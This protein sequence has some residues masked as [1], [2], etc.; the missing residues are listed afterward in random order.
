MGEVVTPLKDLSLTVNKEWDLGNLGTTDMYLTRT[1]EMDLLADGEETGLTGTLNYQ[2]DWS[3]TFTN[4]PQFDSDGVEIEYTVKEVP[5][6]VGWNV[7]YGPV[8]E[9]GENAY[10]T[11][12]TNTYAMT[13]Q[14]PETGGHGLLPYTIGGALL[15]IASGI[16]LL[17]P[18]NTK[19][20]KEGHN[21]S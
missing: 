7:T 13:Y 20:K 1:V 15:V 5:F 17:Y 3:Y 19:R 2:N 9:N 6:D 14:L 12:V 16:L 4:L 10:E 18:Y 11:T 8:T 21:S